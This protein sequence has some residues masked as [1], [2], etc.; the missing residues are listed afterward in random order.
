MTSIFTG[1]TPFCS[2][3]NTPSGKY[4]VQNQNEKFRNVLLGNVFNDRDLISETW[5]VTVKIMS[6]WIDV[7]NPERLTVSEELPLLTPA[8][9][10]SDAGLAVPVFEIIVLSESTKDKLLFEEISF[11]SLSKNK[12]TKKISKRMTTD[13]ST[14]LG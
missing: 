11:F 13:H 1:L 8:M 5:S 3:A 12:N 9:T 7:P 2:A 10:R 4:E 14:K 6:F